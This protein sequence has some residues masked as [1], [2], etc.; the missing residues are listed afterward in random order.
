ML[1][2]GAL[3]RAMGQPGGRLM[4]AQALH[5]LRQAHRLMEAG[6]FAQAFPMFKRLAEGAQERG[7]TARAA[8]LYWLA[9][10][11]RLEMGG[12]QD[13]LD[14]ARQS[15]LLFD[16]AGLIHLVRGLL[17]QLIR[18]LE[19]KGYTQQAVALRAEVESLLGGGSRQEPAA[20][21]RSRLPDK[22]P[23]CGGPVHPAQVK[24]V[25]ERSAECAFC[26][27]VIRAE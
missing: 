7:M 26:G 2:R 23:S 9:A 13:A 8:Q 1:R 3:G 19:A 10:R 11:A 12:A 20:P 27:S 15:V 5:N 16:Q 17:P 24:W 4:E 6:Q 18:P 14:L 25:D 22:C 21:S